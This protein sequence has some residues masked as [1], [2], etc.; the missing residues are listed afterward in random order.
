MRWNP[1]LKEW[2]R[3]RDRG[4]A[5]S[6]ATVLRYNSGDH[7]LSLCVF[8]G[9]SGSSKVD[10]CAVLTGHGGEGPGKQCLG[11]LLLSRQFHVT[12]SKALIPDSQQADG[13]TQLQVILS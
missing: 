5:C 9:E 12:S 8:T 3:S 11:G 4:G 6:L 7:M 10:P 13:N 2:R 1:G